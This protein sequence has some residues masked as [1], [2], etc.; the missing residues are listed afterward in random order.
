MGLGNI[1]GIPIKKR[2]FWKKV[3]QPVFLPKSILTN[4]DYIVTS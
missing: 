1:I 4:Y 2:M 3:S